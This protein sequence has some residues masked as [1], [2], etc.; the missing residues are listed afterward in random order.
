MSRVMKSKMGSF[1]YMSCNHN[2]K[3]C[4]NQRF[5]IAGIFHVVTTAKNVIQQAGTEVAIAQFS[6][7]ADKVDKVY[8]MSFKFA[9]IEC[10]IVHIVA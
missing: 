10:V 2:A 3:G 8:V 9:Y 4:F 5:I 7:V 1:D 6:Q